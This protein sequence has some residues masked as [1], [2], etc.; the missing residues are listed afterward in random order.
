MKKAGVCIEYI[1]YNTE[2]NLGT[3]STDV[4]VTGNA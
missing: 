4:T 2:I 3:C 1:M